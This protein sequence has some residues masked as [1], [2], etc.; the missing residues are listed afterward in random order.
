[1]EARAGWWDD[2]LVHQSDYK[3]AKDLY[4]TVS[5]NDSFHRVNFNHNLFA[6][7]Q[8]KN[9]PTK[10]PILSLSL[11]LG[12][13]FHCSTDATF[14]CVLHVNE[15]RVQP[16]YSSTLAKETEEWV[17]LVNWNHCRMASTQIRDIVCCL[18]FAV[19]IAGLRFCRQTNARSNLSTSWISIVL[20]REFC[21]RQ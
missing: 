8:Y 20:W 16:S 18:L 13:F 11:T 19:F 2:V 10:E 1:M 12:D 7:T 6:N 5:Q 9:R 14:Y 21:R 15:I 4:F 3:R 17:Q